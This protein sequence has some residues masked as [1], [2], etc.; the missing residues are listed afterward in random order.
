MFLY[1]FPF[2]DTPQG[3]HWLTSGTDGIGTMRYPL[4]L[5]TA[6]SLFNLENIYEPLPCLRFSAQAVGPN[7]EILM[8]YLT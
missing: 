4:M 6:C 5:A 7:A 8:P 2:C 1:A 3:T